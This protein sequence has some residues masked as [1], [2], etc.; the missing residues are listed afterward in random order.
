[1][2]GRKGVLTGLKMLVLQPSEQVCTISHLYK[3]KWQ[4]DVTIWW[5]NVILTAFISPH[6]ESSKKNSSHLIMKKIP[7]SLQTFY[8]RTSTDNKWLHNVYV[9]TIPAIVIALWL[10]WP[11]GS[12][13]EF[14]PFFELNNYICAFP[15]MANQNA[16]CE[17]R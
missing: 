7:F 15:E 13:M 17:K 6:W 8:S 5:H 11:M 3:K 9:T 4:K 10:T 1:M 16:L 14:S 2:Q 12:I